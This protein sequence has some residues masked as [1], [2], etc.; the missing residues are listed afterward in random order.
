MNKTS[1][2][3]EA[4]LNKARSESS[5]QTKSAPFTAEL[6]TNR[7]NSRAATTT[8]SSALLSAP[9]RSAN[10]VKQEL[11]NLTL[12]KTF[13]SAAKEATVE[14]LG[15]EKAP[16]QH[17][18]NQAPTSYAGATNNTVIQTC[19]DAEK[20]NDNESV[21]GANRSAKRSLLRKNRCMEKLSTTS[22]T[23]YVVDTRQ[24]SATANS[25]HSAML[26]PP[27][28]SGLIDGRHQ[29]HPPDCQRIKS[30]AACP[31][32]VAV[33]TVQPNQIRA[34]PYSVPTVTSNYA[35]IY[36]HL[37]MDQV[38]TSAAC[39]FGPGSAP[40][41]SKVVAP[42]SYKPYSPTSTSL[43]GVSHSGHHSGAVL[44]P[45]PMNLSRSID[46]QSA[47]SCLSPSNQL[48]L[49]FQ[50][51]Y[52]IRVAT[53]LPTI[54]GGSSNRT[55]PHLHSS[56]PVTAPAIPYNA[57]KCDVESANALTVPLNLSHSPLTGASMLSSPLNPPPTFIAG[58]TP[59][60]VNSATATT[61]SCLSSDYFRS[62]LGTPVPPT[63]YVYTLPTNTTSYFSGMSPN[64]PSPSVLLLH[65]LGNMQFPIVGLPY[66]TS[67]FPTSTKEETTDKIIE[68]GSRTE[69]LVAV[70]EN[71][72]PPTTTVDKNVEELMPVSSI[73]SRKCSNI[74]ITRNSEEEV[75][76]ESSIKSESPGLTSMHVNRLKQS[77]SSGKGSKG[78]N[79][80]RAAADSTEDA[81]ER[82]R[83]LHLNAE[84]SRRCALK[85]GF[86]KLEEL[87]PNLKSNA[88]KI[89]NA[90]ILLKA[91]ER[92]REL[93][94]ETSESSNLIENLKNQIKE[95]NEK[96]KYS[97]NF[98]KQ[99]YIVFEA[100]L[101][102]NYQKVLP[103]QST[104]CRSEVLQQ[105][106]S[107]RVKQSIEADPKFWLLFKVIEPLLESFKNE[108]KGTSLSEVINTARD[109]SSRHCNH[110]ELRPIV[111]QLLVSL[112]TDS[113]ILSSPASFATYISQQI[114]K[115]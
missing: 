104:K 41:E 17:S 30:A 40:V 1:V 54:S 97:I 62:C 71:Q 26:S 115:L 75:K 107:G 15:V 72:T 77:C 63:S 83:L 7:S 82:K 32:Q 42:P 106:I 27:N 102:S 92:T 12:R 13:I 95:L 67:S 21:L 89:T 6:L 61:P 110:A 80:K 87:L 57:N 44:R 70:S 10:D 24:A 50:L 3:K 114:Q 39:N 91:G 100:K 2:P 35:A 14:K 93:K 43:R 94:R 38:A 11:K 101:F 19:L 16:P 47:F 37:G 103:A 60:P 53:I 68:P 74:V 31:K 64:S 52:G 66:S 81:T 113:P 58:A 99:K 29:Q 86:E 69:I 5:N 88:T 76:N 8:A 85:G 49:V 22:D 98:S 18:F 111:S 23:N 112:A 56:P 73:I 45:I 48:V 105:R 78:K 79:A 25:N 20:L 90:V 4:S 65:S 36:N 96:I 51:K 84:Q 46:K 34:S 59:S 108:V 28:E 9:H 55:S 109:W 33:K